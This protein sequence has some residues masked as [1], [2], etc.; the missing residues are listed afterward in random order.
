V[1]VFY[2]LPTEG[3]A[4]GGKFRWGDAEIRNSKVQRT[5][6]LDRFG[7][8][9][10]PYLLYGGLYSLGCRMICFE[11]VPA[12]LIYLGGQGCMD[13]INTSQGIVPGYNSGSFLLY[14]LALSPTQ[15]SRK[16]LK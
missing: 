8:Q 15:T 1:S 16:Q 5:Q 11:G 14:R 7:L 12:P 9:G 3:Y 2:Q 10:A 6:D 4:Q 13:L